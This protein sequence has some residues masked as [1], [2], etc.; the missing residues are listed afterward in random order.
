M[1][2]TARH[3]VTGLD[4]RSLTIYLLYYLSASK[5]IGDLVCKRMQPPPT[6]AARAD[7]AG[8]T[9]TSARLVSQMT[10]TRARPRA[11][12][13][14]AAPFGREGFGFPFGEGPFGPGRRRGRKARRGDV[15]T[16]A[17]ILLAEEPRNGY[18]IMQE[19]ESAATASGGRAPARSTRRCSSSRTRGSCAPRSST[20]ARSSA[21]PRPARPR[22]PSARADA[23]AP[24]GGVHAR[25]QRRRRRA[26]RAHEGGRLRLHAG[27]AGR[28]GEPSWPRPR[29]CSPTRAGRC[30]ASSPTASR[31]TRARAPESPEGGDAA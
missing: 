9:S 19:L 15:R 1:G 28:R 30:T 6:D 5:N 26:G 17:L 23:P 13:G 12:A 2:T 11:A 25:R 10:R 24:M 8:S 4:V 14:R 18:Q 16:A 20:D 29:R 3:R 22:S 27:R 7:A 21:S 31:R